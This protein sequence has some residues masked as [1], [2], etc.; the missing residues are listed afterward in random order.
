MNFYIICCEKVK[1]E[2][3]ILEKELFEGKNFNC[4]WWYSH[5]PVMMVG[6]ITQKGYDKKKK[7]E[8]ELQVPNTC[9]QESA[10]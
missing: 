10:S 6:D 5:H 8:A 9:G 3:D 4:W 7:L 2:L 1:I